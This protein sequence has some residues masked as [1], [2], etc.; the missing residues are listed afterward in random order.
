MLIFNGIDILDKYK[1]YNLELLEI[2]E[3]DSNI[4]NSFIWIS[5]VKPV[6]KISFENGII[7]IR[8]FAETDS[9]SIGRIVNDMING[10]LQYNETFSN[11][12]SL[13]NYNKKE[14]FKNGYEINLEYTSSFKMKEENTLE[15]DDTLSVIYE[16]TLNSKIDFELEVIATGDIEFTVNDVIVL[17]N[18][19][20]AKDRI[21][22]ENGVVEINGELKIDKVTFDDFPFL[23]QG[24]NLITTTGC[25]ATIKYRELFI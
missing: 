18:D 7:K 20:K 19:V 6:N 10:E 13:T 4:N 23:R 21:A 3:N 16:G 8:L 25:K 11:K 9:L 5:G 22:F 15:C 17:V 2:E 24:E 12:V 1:N 14:L